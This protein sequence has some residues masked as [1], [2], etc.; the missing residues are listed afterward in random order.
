MTASALSDSSGRNDSMQ[1]LWGDTERVFCRLLRKDVEGHRHAFMPMLA[2]AEHPMPESI[3]RLAHEYELK[4]YL[5]GTWALRPVDLVREP[6][7]TML[8]VEYAGGEPLDRHLG[9]RAPG[10][11]P[12]VESRDLHAGTRHPE[13]LRSH[14][15]RARR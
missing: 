4:D 7:Q 12:I 8:V 9:A 11:C 15:R 2:G 1:V 5:D 10:V 13:L 6:G 3:N 14:P